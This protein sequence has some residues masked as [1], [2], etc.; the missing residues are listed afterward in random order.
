M[1]GGLFG[2][3]KSEGSIPGWLE[4]PTKRML[5][6]SEAM[7]E[8]GYMPWRGPDVAALS[9]LER[10]AMENTATA[11]NAFG[12]TTPTASGANNDPMNVETITV[13]PMDYGAD[14]EKAK[15]IRD[16]YRDV[17]GRD[18][19]AAGFQHWMSKYDPET[20]DQRFRSAIN[21]PENIDP[22]T[23]MAAPQ[24]FGGVMGYSSAPMYDAALDELRRTQPGTMEHYSK[25]FVDP[26]TGEAGA[27][28]RAAQQ[29]QAAQQGPTQ[30]DGWQDNMAGQRM[31]EQGIASGPMSGGGYT[32]I[33]DMFDGGGPGASG[34]TFQGGGLFSDHANSRKERKK[35]NGG[36]L[37]GGWF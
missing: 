33:R 36:G 3:T 31:Q 32:G 18:P 10:A 20:F 21:N 27:F 11:A 8:V 12:M 2:S 22:L 28:T 14:R 26:M 30:F 15:H 19:D 6:R 4:E 23:G 16:T 1:S 7:A 17:L 35:A 34:D 24:N 13:N 5:E 29:Q 9:P 37:F 25:F